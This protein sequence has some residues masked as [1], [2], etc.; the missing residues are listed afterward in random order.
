MRKLFHAMD[1]LAW[2]DLL[3]VN[4]DR[5]QGQY[6][7]RPNMGAKYCTSFLCEP[8]MSLSYERVYT[9]GQREDGEMPPKQTVIGVTRDPFGHLGLGG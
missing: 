8:V 7:G 5:R 1:C 6:F 2:E 3:E 4:D 9:P